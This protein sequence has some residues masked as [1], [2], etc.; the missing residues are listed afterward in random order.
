M[1][2]DYLFVVTLVVAIGWF[3]FT[4]MVES[5]ALRYAEK[6][7]F[8]KIY[9]ACLWSH[10]VSLVVIICLAWS[11]YREFEKEREVPASE[12]QVSDE[13]LVNGSDDDNRCGLGVAYD[14]DNING[15]NSGTSVK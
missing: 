6:E 2:Y 1:S 5:L 13:L 3:L 9:G 7:F 10:I 4:I 14:V 15:A 12:P 8:V 11:Y